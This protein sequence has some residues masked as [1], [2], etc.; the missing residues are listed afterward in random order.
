MTRIRITGWIAA[1]ALLSMI[2]ALTETF[3]S[4]DGVMFEGTLRKVVPQAAVCNVL[5]ENHTPDEYE[6]LNP[7]HGRVVDLWQVDFAVHNESGQ[8]IEHQQ[9]L[10]WVRVEPPPCTN[11]SG[12]GP[13]GGPL[14]PQHRL[15]VPTVWSDYY[16]MLHRADGLESAP[17]DYYRYAEA[18]EAAGQPERAMAAAVRYLQLEGR[19]A[20]HYT[21]ALDMMTRAEFGEAG[22]AAR[23]AQGGAPAAD[24][25]NSYV[26]GIPP[27]EALAVTQQRK[28]TGK[29]W[30]H[31]PV[32]RML[33][34][35]QE[36]EMHALSMVAHSLDR[37]RGEVYLKDRYE[38]PTFTCV[39]TY[40]GESVRVW[41]LHYKQEARYSNP[42]R[43]M[44]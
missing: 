17:E 15:L 41:R 40:G 1:T 31:G 27:E 8:Q 6:R 3:H 16:Q 22:P 12:E 7:N 25:R 43:N 42:R 38:M 9:A 26:C 30:A 24:S 39:S 32:Q 36:T 11:W 4:Q 20:E 44:P 34:V 28:R 23:P 2:P 37:R 10:G 5:E 35:D 13:G 19:E 29:W 18:W 14:L 21:A 33:L